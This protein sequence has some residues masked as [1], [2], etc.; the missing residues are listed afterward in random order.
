MTIMA[1]YGSKSHRQGAKAIAK[2]KHIEL[3]A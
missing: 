1:E 3:Q 2:S